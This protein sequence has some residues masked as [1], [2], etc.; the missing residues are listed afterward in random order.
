MLARVFGVGWQGGLRRLLGLGATRALPRIFGSGAT[1]ASQ[2]VFGAGTS[3]AL[4]GVSGS[5]MTGTLQKVSGSRMTGALL[6]S[7]GAHLMMLSVGMKASQDPSAEPAA[8][9]LAIV[10]VNAE[11]LRSRL[12]A[13]VLAQVDLEGG[14]HD[15]PSG[16][17]RAMQ[18]ASDEAQAG[19]QALVDVLNKSQAG[20]EQLRQL[21]R[22]QSQIDQRVEDL[23]RLPRSLVYGLNAQGAVWASWA[24]RWVRRVE[25]VGSQRLASHPGRPLGAFQPSA[26]PKQA[27]GLSGELLVSVD[28]DRGGRVLKV[29]VH[30]PS[31]DPELRQ[32]VHTTL[33]AAAPFEPFSV[34]MR[35]EGDVISMV[36][37][38]RFGAEGLRTGCAACPS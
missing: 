36:R 32:L 1:R 16:D 13:E 24:D 3:C 25:A 10:L 37:V 5:R 6:L 7:F 27:A 22:L 38:W 34:P 4:H 23:S 19:A 18:A 21:T 33:A 26:A 15:A 12:P 31:P 8:K 20:S 11:S 2:R 29:Q 28:V 30:S 14:G 17:L 35:R 9:G